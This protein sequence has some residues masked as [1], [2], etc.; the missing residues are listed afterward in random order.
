MNVN[1]L[2]NKL[3][4]IYNLVSQHDLSILGVTESHLLPTMPNSFV[5]VANYYLLRNDSDTGMPKHGVCCYV[6]QSVK[7][8]DVSY[9][10][11]NCLTFLLH[12]YNLQVILVYRPPSSS[13]D[14]N[15]AL[16]DTLI[17][18]CSRGESVLMGDFNLPS[19]KWDSPPLSAHYV[20]PIDNM[21]L[22]CFDSLGLTQWVCEPTYPRSSNILDL[23]FTT[24]PDRVGQVQVPP[25]LPKCDHCPVLIDF[26]YQGY[27]TAD[28]AP[29]LEISCGTR[30]WERGKYGIMS[31]ELALYDWD[32][33]FAALDVNACFERFCEIVNSLVR[34]LVPVKHP[35]NRRPP[36]PTRPP[37]SLI[38][39]RSVHWNNYKSV[40]LVY[41]R[42]SAVAREALSLFTS[43]NVAIHKFH[44]RSQAQYES[45]LIKRMKENPKLFHAYIRHKKTGRVSV[46][47]LRLSTGELSDSPPAMAESFS[48]AFSS[49]YTS[50]DLLAPAPFQKCAETMPDLDIHVQQV[51]TMLLDLDP[52][53][54]VGPDGI[55]PRVLKSCA[56]VLS[57]PL[58]II[59]R[60][61]LSERKLPAHWKKSVIIPIH[62][63]G[64]KYDPLNY[65][66]LSMTSI[67]CK[68]L[69]TLIAAELYEYLECHS[70]ITPHQYGFRP[71]HTTA[72]Q[73]T[74]VY[75]KISKQV[76]LCRV[77]DMIFFDFSK[78]FDVVS[79]DILLGKLSD[80]GVRGQ[81]LDWISDFLIGRTMC[82]EVGGVQSAPRP[83]LSGVP[84]G[85]V[86]GPILFLIYV[87]NIAATLSSDYKIF[88]DD[89]KMYCLIPHSTPEQY[90]NATSACQSDIDRLQ[91]VGS[92]WGL[93][94]NSSKCVVMR[95][96]RRGTTLPS[97]H[98]VLNQAELKLVT[99]HKDLGVVV[100]SDLKFHSHVRETAHKAGGLAH[101]LIRATVCRS[102]EFMVSLFTMHIRPIIDYCSSVWFT[103]YLQD[104]RI[105]EAV[106]R[107][108]TKQIAG[109]ADLDYGQ[110]LRSLSLYSIQGRLMRTDLIFYWKI[111]TGRSSIPPDVMFQFAPPLGTRG[112]NLKLSVPCCNTDLR[113]RSFSVRRISEWNDLPQTVVSASSLN[114]FKR[115]LATH[116]GDKLYDY[117]D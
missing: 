49:V 38:R 20:T 78:A 16:L 23:F 60:R 67:P 84:Q 69:E 113:K 48:Q 89:L 35:I 52:F 32:F 109:F 64:A 85:S 3:P 73:L 59:Y 55:H 21:F 68:K 41:G 12:D 42:H 82:V 106:Q 58:T 88:A 117:L 115:A 99:S 7:V 44:I 40:R 4:S 97:P 34:E 17:T 9:P 6:H 10:C 13:P 37:G 24:D 74:L 114:V 30:H 71:G 14:H 116:L 75:D 62:K 54:A 96:K 51:E 5:D 87:N 81:V 25:P 90:S 107:R 77:V 1:G 95:F 102:P 22:D 27:P 110:R 18:V 36:W 101:N 66:P 33:E 70:L 100:D 72:D 94:M 108:W 43:T 53:T 50:H 104:I 61:S 45:S 63:K 39:L 65:R 11:Q 86:L 57:Y 28:P 8:V 98:Y 83:V 111:L 105:L 91:A 19:L 2:P 76:D 46:G 29:C 79:H 31:R 15:E 47:P 93:S 56:P 103:G 92:S 26:I 80:L 112:H